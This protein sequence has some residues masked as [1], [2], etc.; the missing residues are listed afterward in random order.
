SSPSLLFGLKIEVSPV[1]S[2]V[3]NV[4][5]VFATTVGIDSRLTCRLQLEAKCRTASVR[6]IMHDAD[7]CSR[8]IYGSSSAS[9]LGRNSTL[10]EMICA[11]DFFVRITDSQSRHGVDTKK[12]QWSKMAPKKE[13]DRMMPVSIQSIFYSG[14]RHGK[15]TWCIRWLT[16]SMLGFK[17]S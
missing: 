12:H 7:N 13:A 9:V 16:F 6:V 11:G 5:G 10:N 14:W 1:L 8:S 2:E 4:F 3:A 15:F 17:D